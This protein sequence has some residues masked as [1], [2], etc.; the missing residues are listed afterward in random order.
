M[1]RSRRERAGRL[2]AVAGMLAVLVLAFAGPI[3]HLHA[4]ARDFGTAHHAVA[5]VP[6]EDC[7]EGHARHGEAPPAKQPANAPV[8]CPVCTLGKMAAA[9]LA[10]SQ[11]ALTVP[12]ALGD[13]PIAV[14][15]AAPDGIRPV[16][17]A[18]PR[19]PPVEA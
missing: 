10:P 6:A 4:I 13:P 5:A 9:L 12:L 7:H 2:G 18:R 14:A 17:I 3:H 11:P 1:S 16:G 8:Y 19:A 15:T